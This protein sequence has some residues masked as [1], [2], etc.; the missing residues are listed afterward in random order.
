MHD[1]TLSGLFLAAVDAFPERTFMRRVGD[2]LDARTTYRQGATRLAAAV[3]RLAAVGLRAGDRL[4]CWLDAVGPAAYATLACAHLGVVLVPLPESS[5]LDFVR[6][7]AERV[8]ARAVIVPPT[9]AEPA[10]TLGLPVLAYDLDDRDRRG[11]LAE[12]AELEPDVARRALH[13]LSAQRRADEPCIVL[14]TSGTTGEPKLILRTAATSIADVRNG[15]MLGLEPRAEPP[16]RFLMVSA[17]VHAAGQNTLYTALALAAELS[18]PGALD[19]DCSLD[20]VRALDPTYMLFAPRVLRA[21][22]QR[23]L[24]RGETGALFG[25]GARIVHVGGAAS[26]P[27]LLRDVA[28]Q[29]LDVIEGYG[30]SEAG[31]LVLTPRGEWREGWAGKALP[32]VSLR[33]AD[34]GE[35]LARSSVPMLEYLGDE[36]QTRAAFTDEGFYRTGDF[37]EIDAEGWVRIVGRKVDVFNTPKGSNI[38]PA[39][40]ELLVEALPWVA[41]VVLLG[42]QL[43]F[44][45]ALVVLRDPP[46]PS[47]PDSGADGWLD[48]ARHVA[49]HE[50]ARVELAAVNRQLEEDERIRRVALFA[51]P[52]PADA[53]VA[54]QAGKTRRARKVIA[55]RY[56]E[57][58]RALYA[59]VSAPRIE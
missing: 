25:P 15:W 35:L 47:D 40:V 41:Q 20:E 55:A 59:D 28:A 29:G 6:R 9:L 18:I 30:T 37:A 10:S 1:E 45:A 16:Q 13:A 44:V 50:R 23:Q 36:A 52:F 12:R 39:R 46:A 48:P 8:G 21:L 54:V 32:H 14:A 11:A 4:V 56:A 26:E 19:V 22:R 3:E 57:R 43:P 7:V 51:R 5:S 24:A 27:A 53:Y 31:V 34:D 33:L 17:L 38:Y 2:G 58:I 49:L 42:D